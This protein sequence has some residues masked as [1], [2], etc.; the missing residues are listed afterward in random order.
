MREIRNFVFSCSCQFLAA[1]CAAAS[2][3]R[4]PRIKPNARQ[5][6][7]NLRNWPERMHAIP[8]CILFH[9]KSPF[10]WILPIPL[11]LSKN[12]PSAFPQKPLSCSCCYRSAIS[13]LFFNKN[14]F[15]AILEACFS[16]RFSKKPR[17]CSHAPP[18]VPRGTILLN[19]SYFRLVKLQAP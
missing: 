8:K 10:C 18:S 6:Y 1:Q 7:Q 15:N 17:F 5:N 13:T 16:A 3:R 9:F 2:W 4:R 12:H 11:I 19:L 14:P